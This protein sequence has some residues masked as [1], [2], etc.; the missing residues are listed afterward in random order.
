MSSKSPAGLPKEGDDEEN[1]SQ[2][3]T[4]RIGNE[5]REEKED[6]EQK[7]EIIKEPKYYID[8]D[9]CSSFFTELFMS[10]LR[11]PSSAV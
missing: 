8:K 7:E 9:F 6:E 2:R 1:G 5:G 3:L 4:G 10:A 11:H